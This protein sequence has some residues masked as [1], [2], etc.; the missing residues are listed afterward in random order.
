MQDVCFWWQK[1][2][3]IGVVV[4]GSGGGGGCVGRDQLGGVYNELR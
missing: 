2:E 3:D 1:Y 4:G